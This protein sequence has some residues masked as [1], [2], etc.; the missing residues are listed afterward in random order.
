MILL[1]KIL[2]QKVKSG[3][4]SSQFFSQKPLTKCKTIID[5]AKIIA[6]YERAASFTP[7]NWILVSIIKNK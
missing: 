6:E 3:D 1:P 4:K 2:G 5:T 7:I